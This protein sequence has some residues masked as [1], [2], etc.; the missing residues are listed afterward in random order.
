MIYCQ[1]TF[2]SDI[3]KREKAYKK[4]KYI[5]FK[6]SITATVVWTKTNVC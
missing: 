2:V 6:N 3:C 4:V 1:V 5:C